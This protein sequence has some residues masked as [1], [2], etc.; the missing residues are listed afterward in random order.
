MGKVIFTPYARFAADEDA[1]LKAKRE[2]LKKRLLEG[3]KV[4]VGRQGNVMG[5]EKDAVLV[6][7]ENTKLAAI[8]Q[9]YENDPVLLNAEKA[10]MNRAFP[11]FTLEKLPD[12]RLYWQGALNIGVMG[13]NVWHV[14]AVYDNNHPRQIMGSSVKVYLVEPDIDELIEG[15]GWRPHHLLVDSVGQTY[16]CT[17]EAQF[18]KATKS[19]ST[20][21]LTVM[22]W[23]IKW[24]TAFEL[25]LTG[26]LSMEDFN[27]PGK[28]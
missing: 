6:T 16:L 13:D 27:T 9:W 21:A 11:D 20:S 8:K 10:A 24:L 26:D 19:T 15:L 23:A 22:G 12:G 3:K 18:V 4:M 28:I 2:E 17:T 7:P 14:M 25:V 1:A 5:K